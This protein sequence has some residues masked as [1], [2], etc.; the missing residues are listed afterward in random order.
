[1]WSEALARHEVGRLRVTELRS[2]DYFGPGT[3][4]RTSYLNDVVFDSTLTQQTFGL[5]P[6]PWDDAL[7]ATIASRRR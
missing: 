5:A 7:T 1:M 3:T 2:S 6:T 4:P